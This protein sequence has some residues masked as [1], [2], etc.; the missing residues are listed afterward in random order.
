MGYRFL[1]DESLGPYLADTLAPETRDGIEIEDLS[2]GPVALSHNLHERPPYDRLVLV[3]SV[4]R[5]RA[6]G[7]IERYR[8]NGVLPDTTEI[9]ARVGEAVTG[10]ISLDNLLV[11]CGVLGGLPD[12]VRVVEVE[13]VEP[14]GWGDGFSAELEAKLPEIVEAVWT[15]TAP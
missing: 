1:R 14:E 2:Y 10:V 12:D 6:P 11:V 3:A 7:T 15:S 13:P 4:R 5:G 8:W 9:Q